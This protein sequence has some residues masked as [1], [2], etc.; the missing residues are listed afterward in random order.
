MNTS[1]PNGLLP[2]GEHLAG[3]GDLVGG[4][5]IEAQGTLLRYKVEERTRVQQLVHPVLSW[6]ARTPF[7]K[8]CEWPDR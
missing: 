6:A 4:V 5:E 8:N 2:Y 7:V 1:E 3:G